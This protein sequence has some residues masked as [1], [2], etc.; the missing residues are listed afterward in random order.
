MN[1][2]K[3]S[4]KEPSGILEPKILQSLSV[5][6]HQ[7]KLTLHRKLLKKGSVNLKT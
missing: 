2:N 7:V 3:H 6:N 5:K 4:K 1:K